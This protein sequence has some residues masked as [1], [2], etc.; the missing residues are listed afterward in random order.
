MTSWGQTHSLVTGI[1]KTWEHNLFSRAVR[2]SRNPAKP[3]LSNYSHIFYWQQLAEATDLVSVANRQRVDQALVKI[4]NGIHS[5]AGAVSRMAHALD[6]VEAFVLHHR[7]D[8]DWTDDREVASEET[9][10][11]VQMSL[12]VVQGL[13]DESRSTEY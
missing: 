1:V 9:L 4:A 13:M 5:Q 11:F 10:R 8:I 2:Y 12:K 3:L 6:Q 7:A